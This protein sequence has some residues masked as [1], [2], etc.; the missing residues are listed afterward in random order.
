MKTTAALLRVACAVALALFA[1][2]TLAADPALAD[3]KLLSY[4]TARPIGPSNMGGR[5][6]DV[7]IVENQPATQFIATASGG[8]WKTEN[9]GVTWAPVFDHEKTISLGAV[10][11]APSNPEVVWLGTGEANARNSASWGDGVYKS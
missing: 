3:A 11:V 2:P 7:A 10:A 1:R 8:L 6:V 4:F 5:V 9:N